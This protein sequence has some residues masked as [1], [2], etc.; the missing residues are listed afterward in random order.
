MRILALV[1]MLLL[2][3]CN[4]K[5][6]GLTDTLS[7]L[8]PFS[9]KIEYT[10]QGSLDSKSYTEF[11]NF[12]KNQK[13]IDELTLYLDS[14]GGEIV[15]TN[16]I[17]NEIKE[18]KSLGTKIIIIVGDGK[19]C[20]SSCTALFTVG[21]ERIAHVNSYWIFHS[22]FVFKPGYNVDNDPSMSK[23]D[24]DWIHRNI[25]E[26]RKYFYE[27]IFSVDPEFA[28]FLNVNYFLKN[29]GRKVRY[30]GQEL[31]EISKHY[32]TNTIND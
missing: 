27:S 10:I 4:T 31:S 13:V 25:E 7:T 9:T 26:S 15:F 1:L 5:L 11:N 32:L 28:K 14:S 6:N 12:V 3:G 22:P 8:N 24:R 29:D 23:E 17:A 2:S 18:L 21:D 19:Q 30:S 20:S 16:L